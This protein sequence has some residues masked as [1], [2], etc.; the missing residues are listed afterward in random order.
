MFAAGAV[1]LSGLVRLALRRQPLPLIWFSG[2][3]GI[4]L[5]G[6][7]GI[8]VP[9]WWRFLLLAQVPLAIGTAVILVEAR[10]P[11]T[12]WT[13]RAT[14]VFVLVFKLATLIAVS[15]RVTYFGNPLQPAYSIGRFIPP[16]P[17]GLVATDPFTSYYIPAVSGRRVLTVT[18]A[19]VGSQAELDAATRGYSLLHRFYIASDS[20]WWPSAQ[21]LWNAGVRFV[22]VEKRTSLA[23]ATLE[24]FSTGPTPL[25]RTAADEHLL[26]RM[27]WRLRR[28]G[29]LVHDDPEYAL[30][31]LD[32]STL[33]PSPPSRP[34]GDRRRS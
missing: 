6:L 19:H 32:G 2:C 34:A 26:G 25:V 14:L 21:A 4:A 12:R 5:L 20:D 31:E 22:L 29:R 23:P 7:I 11:V 15:P 28:I 27:H 18:K 24:Q 16:D 33:F 1:G 13:L 8:P 10:A 9:V 3:F 17:P 30:Y